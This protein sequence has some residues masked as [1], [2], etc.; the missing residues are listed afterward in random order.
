MSSAV[1]DAEEKNDGGTPSPT[2]GYNSSASPSKLDDGEKSDKPATATTTAAATQRRRRTSLTNKLEDMEGIDSSLLGARVRRTSITQ[3]EMAQKRSLVRFSTSAASARSH[4]STADDGTG[5]GEP[6]GAAS[7]PKV[8]TRAN[9]GKLRKILG[10]KYN[11]LESSVEQWLAILKPHPVTCIAAGTDACVIVLANGTVFDFYGK[12]ATPRPVPF[13][14]SAGGVLTVRAGATHFVAITRAVLSNAYSWGSKAGDWL[15]RPTAASPSVPGVIQGV[16]GRVV[17]ATCGAD[18]TIVVTSVGKAFG[19][20]SNARG[21]LGVD[22]KGSFSHPVQL[23]WASGKYALRLASQG[24]HSVGV[25]TTPKAIVLELARALDH[26]E[27]PFESLLNEGV[28]LKLADLPL[29][30]ELLKERQAT[31]EDE[32]ELLATAS[33][34]RGLVKQARE[35]LEETSLDIA[36]VEARAETARHAIVPEEART[37]LERLHLREAELTATAGRTAR[38]LVVV[39]TH[40][41]TLRA[42][43]VLLERCA[44]RLKRHLQVVSSS[45]WVAVSTPARRSKMVSKDGMVVFRIDVDAGDMV[46]VK[47]VE[48]VGAVLTRAATL[49]VCEDGTDG[50]PG[51]CKIALAEVS[52]AN[53]TTVRLTAKHRCAVVTRRTGLCAWLWVGMRSAGVRLVD[54]FEVKV[55]LM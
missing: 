25:R 26:V 22:D 40:M 53:E 39:E 41:S 17:E 32:A 36:D 44:L 12:N 11:S 50:E 49:V 20:G 27:Q 7:Y 29:G 37:R 21:Q 15:G 43:Q 30:S 19:L 23:H 52:S 47:A 35:A 5:D 46:V 4:G 33:E 28:Y 45:G 3:T 9:S 54:D 10:D 1:D 8:A 18:F 55:F 14:S 2:R 24:H 6:A 48:L 13:P 51:A 34:L 31:I 42:R 16:Q 38:K